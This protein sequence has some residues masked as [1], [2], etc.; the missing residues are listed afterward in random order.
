MYRINETKK[1]IL[2]I[3]IPASISLVSAGVFGIIDMLFISW[4]GTETTAAVG[5]T[6]TITAV[7]QAIGFTIGIG[8][9]TQVSALIGE[10]KKDEAGT[11]VSVALVS[12]IFI[13][14]IIAVCGNVY[15]RD[16]L[17]VLGANK[18]VVEEGIWYARAVFTTAPVVISAHILNNTLRG[19][20]KAAPVMY[21][22]LGTGV[23]NSVLEYVLIRKMSF[24][25]AGASVAMIISQIVCVTG[26]LTLYMVKKTGIKL[27][28]RGI[29][30]CL[31]EMAEVIKYGM[32]G[33]FRQGLGC[34]SVALINRQASAFGDDKVAAMTIN[35]RI[36]LIIYSIVIGWGQALS[37]MAGF[38]KEDKDQKRLREA[39]RF[40][41]RVCVVIMIGF[42][43]LGYAF[44][45]EISELFVR[46]KN[47]VWKWTVKAF[48][49][50][51]A[52]FPFMV[53]PVMINMI[54]Q[55]TRKTIISTFIASLRQ[56]ICM[57][58]L[59]IILPQVWG[60]HGI[61]L[62]QPVADILTF[63]LIL[64][65]YF[66]IRRGSI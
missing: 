17:R 37:A 19:E 11:V 64:P 45:P 59:I 53:L 26:L 52:V 66:S 44:A 7:I 50:Q 33:L 56:G 24:G 28:F 14:V 22:L 21:V 9:G 34:I 38:C 48:R 5:I 41:V 10:N 3:A 25:I 31:N 27:K 57:I 16:I 4:L 63:I 40:C 18:S 1:K 43:I 55:G 62:S 54:F 13:G 30:N 15:T 60:A 61:I 20:G 6:S 35:G 58:P 32:S 42:G 46:G 39:Y 29:V 36:Y 65:F 12:G 8:A 2:G 47:D 49:A 51:C 23:I